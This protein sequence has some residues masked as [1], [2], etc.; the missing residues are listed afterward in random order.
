MEQPPSKKKGG[1]KERRIAT[2]SR[3]LAGPLILLY[4][5][6][7]ILGVGMVC[8]ITEKRRNRKRGARRALAAATTSS[9]VASS[10][11]SIIIAGAGVAAGDA[12]GLSY[13]ATLAFGASFLLRRRLRSLV[14]CSIIPS[15]AGDRMRPHVID[16]DYHTFLLCWLVGSRRCFWPHHHRG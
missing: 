14:E 11:S 4:R 12:G 13:L 16:S 2:L 7:Y 3:D 1:K 6:S 5:S 9:S 10:S 15:H 8:D